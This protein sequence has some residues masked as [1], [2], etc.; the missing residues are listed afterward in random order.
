MP[1][2]AI[3][4]HFGDA[5]YRFW[6]PMARICEVEKL[7]GDKSI[8]VMHDELGQG[9]GKAPGQETVR[10][11]DGGAARI[12]DV[13]EIIRCA[14]IGGGERRDGE[15]VSKV[16]A[17]DAK[18]LV[19][20]YVDGRPLAETIPVAWS[21]LR[22]TI[23]GVSLKKKADEPAGQDEQSHSE[24][25]SFSPTADSSGSTGTASPSPAT[26]K[27]SKRETRA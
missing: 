17:L 1:D 27:R 2:T 18:H 3:D 19:D 15:R 16:S 24:R 14:A 6:L 22:A 23:Y 21:I 20:N 5:E 26:S 12:R 13:Y 25:D 7:C 11:V 4:L 9:L 10:L 8:L